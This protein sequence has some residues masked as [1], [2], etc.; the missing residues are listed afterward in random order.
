[1]NQWRSIKS[2]GRLKYLIWI[3]LLFVQM[4]E[5]AAQQAQ[6]TGRVLDGEG[7]ALPGVS[8]TVKGTSNATMSDGEGRF[9]LQIASQ[10]AVLR[11][12]SVGYEVKELAL[13]GEKQVEVTLIAES[14]AL[15]EIVVIGYGAVAKSDLT[16]SVAS[17][18]AEDLTKGA[19]MNMQQALQ[20]RTPGV[21]IYQKSGEPGAA[22]SVQIRGITSI[23]GN[24][25]PLYV[26]DGMP[27][28][29]AAAI[30][31]ASVGGATNNPNNRTPLNALNPADI[32]SI[33]VLKDASA[34]AIYGSRGANGV[35]LIT[36]KKGKDG[37]ITVAYDASYGQQQVANTQR[38]MTGEE[39]SS[40]INGIID[41]GQLN[42]NTFQPVEGIN[43]NTDWQALLLRNA[44]IQ[45]HDV[46]FSGG[47]NLTKYH[48]SVGYFDQE[49]IMLNSSTTR[50]NARVNLET[51]VSSKYNIGINLSTAYIKDRY[52]AN[53]T[54]VND[55]ASA[56]YM[57][58]NYDPTVPAYGEDGSYFRSPLMAPMDNPLAVINGQYTDGATYRTFG[59]LYA[60]YFI[61]PSLSAKARVGTD[62]NISQRNFWIDPSTLT[63]AS[64][65]G[66]ADARD[67]KRT[68]YLLE[69]TLNYNKTFGD[70]SLSAVVGSTYEYYT[71]SVLLANSR[72]FP[73]SDLTYYGIGWGDAT[74]NRVDNG[75][76]E[77]ILLSYLG[78]VN[79]SFAG[80]YLFTGSIRADGSARFGSEQR[81]GYFPS[82]AFAWKAKE[83]S[84][85]QDVS[86][87]NDLKVRASFGMTGNQPNV[88]Y[89]YFSTYAQ[90]RMAVFDGQRI[91]TIAPTRSSNPFLRWE[92]A[93]QYDLG[94]D[95]ALFNARI[96][97]TLD[98]YNRRT[99]N[100]LYNVPQPLSTGFGGRTE[101]VGSMQNTGVEFSL[102]GT[103]IEHQDF[104]LDAGF[105]ITTLKNK[106][107][108]LGNVE[109][110]I[111]SG[112][113]NVGQYSILKPGESM[114]SFYG[115]IV[116]G[117]WQEGD[118]FSL[119]QPGV[120]PGDLKYRD[121]DNNRVINANDRTILGSSLPDFYY[122]FNV[123]MR[124]KSFG[125]SVFF[126]GSKGAMM[127]NSSLMDSYYPVD[128]RRNKLAELYLNRWTAANPSNEYPSFIP[129]DVQGARPVTNKTVED[130]SYLR[131]QSVR[132]SYQIPLPEKFFVRTATLFVNGQNLHT[133][134]NYS[135]A[136]PA[137]NAIGDDILRV[138]YNSYP[139]TRTF[140]AGLNVQF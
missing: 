123:N 20:G 135:G 59:N 85:L 99:S 67:G 138:D 112:P 66:Y 113:G 80:K 116:D 101:N 47:N 16:G 42:R 26:I 40:A 134:T 72:D 46:A 115:Y 62:I 131:L 63:G 81:F 58:Q 127:L 136:D 76:E 23:T 103:V 25:A 119:A 84:F 133:F 15:D 2:I 70:H 108:S 32:A 91:N 53:G 107:L 56:L 38:Y 104:N 33:E 117:V 93:N 122:G 60:E 4:Q 44:P 31:P 86:F 102:N 11:F 28:N 57:A 95:F 41:E 9:S 6:V 1:M 13:N 90:G 8:V 65:N 137:V 125:L 21:Q 114:G 73:L 52:N 35:V 68:Y 118:D 7:E 120:R 5:L 100:L 64:Y 82:A 24:N 43:H 69:G 39:Y 34:T 94:V 37:Q 10:N 92:S 79:Y 128:F 105:N 61:L 78:R 87:L 98:Y 22:M 3:C 129:G 51:G 18:K 97:G 109:E 124:Y 29:D 50:Y 132:F 139:L 71:S 14:T 83:E 88:N 96:S 36:T 27:V 54:G 121:M 30:G 74:L 110:F 140:L 75:A 126:E 111:G 19:N 130:A 12:S 48:V 55:N 17:V 106:I 49:G 89:L 45:S 77:N